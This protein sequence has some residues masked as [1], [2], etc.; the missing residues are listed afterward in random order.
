MHAVSSWP[1]VLSQVQHFL[2]PLLNTAWFEL[3]GPIPTLCNLPRLKLMKALNNMLAPSVC[4]VTH[5]RL[6]IKLC[7]HVLSPQQS[8]PFLTLSLPSVMIL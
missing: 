6:H 7:F 1:A 3:V 4:F 5:C 2:L 8:S